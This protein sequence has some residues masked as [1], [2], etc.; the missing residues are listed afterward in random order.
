MKLNDVSVGL[1]F[2]H[3]YEVKYKRFQN[4]EFSNCNLISFN[5]LNYSIKENLYTNS[6][7]LKNGEEVVL[8]NINDFELDVYSNKQ[9]YYFF[10]NKIEDIF[11]NFILYRCLF[12]S[13]VSNKN[14][15]Y[16]YQGKMKFNVIAGKIDEN[17]I[18]FT[19]NNDDWVEISKING[20]LF[21][22][23]NSSENIN[24]NKDYILN[25]NFNQNQLFTYIDK[26]NDN[27]NEPDSL[28]FEIKQTLKIVKFC[29]LQSDFYNCL[30]NIRSIRN[31]IFGYIYEQI[32]IPIYQRLEEINKKIS[33][34]KDILNKITNK[35]IWANSTEITEYQEDIDV[36]NKITEK[37]IKW[38]KKFE[39]IN[40]INNKEI[41]TLEYKLIDEKKEYY[42][43][44]IY[45]GE[46][47]F[48]TL[49]SEK[50]STIN[51]ESNKII[52]YIKKKIL[53]NEEINSFKTAN[54]ITNNSV[55]KNNYDRE[56][57]QS[58]Y[59]NNNEL[60]I[61]L[62]TLKTYINIFIKFR[63]KINFYKKEIDEITK[64]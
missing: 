4:N 48:Q 36:K 60:D 29:V 38:H 30:I 62:D 47:T 10:H 14:P 37:I 23:L 28:S 55:H 1:F 49:T 13:K 45:F 16:F 11:Y 40:N 50:F 6:E 7:Q 3:N 42:K 39:N 35:E 22:K 21:K 27:L 58:W 9:N 52:N 26:I 31:L 43:H 56:S 18:I 54:L 59:L 15:N 20:L 24:A 57:F 33:W 53:T 64:I 32:F 12:L 44:P 2:V 5:L 17:S 34:N 25:I 46:E 8:W 41:K 19:P 51:I 63:E 61:L